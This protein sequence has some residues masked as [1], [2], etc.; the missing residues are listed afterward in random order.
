VA[1]G[2][3]IALLELLGVKGVQEKTAPNGLTE[4]IWNKKTVGHVE[5]MGA[6][7]L[8]AFG[9]KQSVYYINFDI[10]ALLNAYQSKKVVYK[11][12]SKYPSIERDLALVIDKATPFASIESSISE[13][14][15]DALHATRVFDIFES[16]K[17]GAGKKSVA[18][19]FVF[20]ATDKT[21]TDVEIDAMMKKLIQLFE[22]NIQAE[23]RK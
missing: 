18:I 15:L 19:N 20:N 11:E 1:K 8:Q 9:I 12:V 16:D 17:L 13:A 22:K 23:I 14:K 4:F 5:S 7:K 3:A 2:T 21:L 6:K 10:A